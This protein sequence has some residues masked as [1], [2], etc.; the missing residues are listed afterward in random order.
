M[1]IAMSKFW[2]D[3]SHLFDDFDGAYLF[4]SAL[5]NCKPR[6]ID[7]ILIYEDKFTAKLK[8]ACN[9]ARMHIFKYFKQEVHLTVLSKS[10]SNEIQIL[11]QVKSLRI[12]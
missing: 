5:D 11:D 12:K 1:N 9:L 2:D 4:G 7:L 10:E 8:Q 6:D 3:N